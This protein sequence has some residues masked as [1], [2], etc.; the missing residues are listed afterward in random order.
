MNWDVIVIGGGP[1]GM[2]A[3]LAAHERGARVCLIER[4]KR[5][6]GILK[7]CIH[8]GFGL[9]Y[10]KERLTGPEYAGR[11]TAL[12]REAEI[13]VYRETFLTS[14]SRT[15]GGFRLKLVNDREG[16]FPLIGT[17]LVLASGCRERTDR[18]VFIQGDRPAGIYTAGLAQNLI[19]LRGVLP[20][21]RCVILGSG[22]IGLIMARRL[23]LEG[24]EVEGVYEIRPEPAGLTR[25]LVQCLDD[26]GIPLHLNT[27]V[28][29]VHGQ[30]RVEAVTV[31]GVDPA[32]QLLPGT[33]R[34]IPC[35]GLILSVGLI[36]ETDILSQLDVP[37]DARTRGPLV[38]DTLETAEPGLFCCGNALHV[39]D[40]VDYVTESGLAAGR[41]AAQKAL[42]CVETG[43]PGGSAAGPVP[44]ERIPIAVTGELATCVPQYL[45]GRE[46]EPAVLWLRAGRVLEPGLLRVEAD[47]KLVA[48]KRVRRIAPPEM[49]K[50]EVNFDGALARAR[51]VS[52][53][54]VEEEPANG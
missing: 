10:F 37:L 53:S 40:L 51:S 14:L 7:Q 52:I 8:D 5:L 33:L 45:T 46:D 22:D 17:T 13:T 41:N 29:E 43:K 50:L 32:G 18:Q 3:A 28:V 39:N 4:E 15:H 27:T 44:R 30:Q 12:I 23:T 19:N 21:R 6:G 47:G 16:L 2:A 11:F 1:A 54:L 38:D 36:P 42:S 48:E 9:L 25:N 35:D 20:C 34:R 24:A 49:E 31:A 26:F